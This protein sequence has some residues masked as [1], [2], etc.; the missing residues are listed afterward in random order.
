[1]GHT[2]VESLPDG[3]EQGTIALLLEGVDSLV[4]Q[5][6]TGLLEGVIAGLQVNEAELEVQRRGKGLKDTTASLDC[7]N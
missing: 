3:T 4:R 2:L 6:G 5:S 1:M 7:V